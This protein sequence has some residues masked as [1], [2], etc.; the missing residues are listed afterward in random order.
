M[1]QDNTGIQETKALKEEAR[2]AGLK[3]L[4]I[5]RI[6]GKKPATVSGYGKPRKGGKP[7]Q[8][9]P[10]SHRLKLRAYLSNRR[11]L[12]SGRRASDIP[13]VEPAYP[14]QRISRAHE[15]IEELG[16]VTQAD[17][18]AWLMAIRGIEAALEAVLPKETPP[19]TRLA[20]RTQIQELSQAPPTT[21]P[22]ERHEPWPSTNEGT[23]R[24]KDGSINSTLPERRIKREA[25]QTEQRRSSERQ[26]D[27]SLSKTSA[28]NQASP[29]H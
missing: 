22:S 4:D 10:I 26:I 12:G 11:E 13:K 18:T 19:D 17:D 28:T 5:A 29:L 25:I 27:D 24:S 14:S 23:L 9:M 15:L 1:S 7:A 2:A 16:R 21:P 3:I 20:V 8:P 6:I